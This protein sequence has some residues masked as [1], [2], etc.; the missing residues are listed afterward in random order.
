MLRCQFLLCA[1]G[2]DIQALYGQDLECESD[3]SVGQIVLNSGRASIDL[4]SSIPYYSCK[5]SLIFSA[6]VFFSVPSLRRIS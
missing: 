6:S 3:W 2:S 4:F 5:H 1:S